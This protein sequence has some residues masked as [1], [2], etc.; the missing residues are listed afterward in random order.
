MAEHEAMIDAIAARDVAQADVLAKAHADQIVGQIQQLM[1]RD[2]R[3]E[4]AL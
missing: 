1:A 3:Q 2:R 4:I